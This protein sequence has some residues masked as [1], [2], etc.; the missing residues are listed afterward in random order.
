MP[1]SQQPNRQLQRRSE[2]G[3]PEPGAADWL[4]IRGLGVDLQ[5]DWGCTAWCA[6]W[7]LLTLRVWLEDLLGELALFEVAP[8]KLPGKRWPEAISRTSP[9][10]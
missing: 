4:A 1:S 7:R 2:R 10:G 8:P 9:Y 3:W 5:G 6:E